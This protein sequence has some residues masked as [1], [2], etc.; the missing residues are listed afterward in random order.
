MTTSNKLS[1]KA[2]VDGIEL[3][4][5]ADEPGEMDAEKTAKFYTESVAALQK[6]KSDDPRTEPKLRA[7]DKFWKGFWRDLKYLVII[8]A[9][10][11]FAFAVF[12]PSDDRHRWPTRERSERLD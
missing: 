5:N 6:F 1:A 2:I 11:W 9:V 8:I 7:K 10:V 12:Y 4:W 3:T